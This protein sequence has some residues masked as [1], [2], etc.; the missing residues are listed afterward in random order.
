MLNQITTFPTTLRQC[1]QLDETI[2]MT[3]QQMQ[4]IRNAVRALAG[5]AYNN[6]TKQLKGLNNRCSS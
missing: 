2:E 4:L 5:N 1:L 3:E 6:L